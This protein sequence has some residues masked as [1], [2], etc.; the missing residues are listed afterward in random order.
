MYDSQGKLRGSI[1]NN[2][3]VQTDDELFL[4]VDGEVG[5]IIE[6]KDIP[7]KNNVAYYGYVPENVYNAN[8]LYDL[9][10][11]EGDALSADSD[12]YEGAYQIFTESISLNNESLK[13]NVGDKRTLSATILPT[14]TTNSLLY[15][16]SSDD[17][18]AKVDETTGEVE[19]VAKGTVTIT[20][21]TLDGLSAECAIEVMS[22]G[23]NSG[24]E[25]PK[26][27]DKP[28]STISPKPTKPDVTGN[29]K[30]TNG[31]NTADS[32]LKGTVLK[33]SKNKVAY[34]V[35]EQ[36]KTVTFY[37]VDNK[38]ITK[39]VIPATVSLNGIKYKVTAISDNAFNGC[40]KLKSVTIGKFVTTIGNKAFFKCIAL[41]KITIPASVTKIGKKAFY[42]CKKLKS[43]T[44]KTKKLKSK[45]VGSQVFKDI[46][47][48]A[49]VKVPKKQKKAYKKWL[50]KKGITKK[51]KIK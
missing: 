10:A 42:G 17:R 51:M 24:N 3:V 46:Y 49:V 20:A 50:R 11:D 18:I 21:T 40:K 43:I 34:K 27:T 29:S 41:K 23:E 47:K 32:P 22:E 44:I 36:G 33:D 28:D 25:T 48:K 12:N 30:P 39:V 35:L 14:N 31:I 16:I 8:L 4:Y 2:E 9:V 38:K 19:A 1:V 15:W 7:L 13:L 26:T 6:Y 45:F 37:K 5:R